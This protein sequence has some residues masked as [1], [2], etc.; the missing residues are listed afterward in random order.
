MVCACAV[1]AGPS[2]CN[3]GDGVGGDGLEGRLVQVRRANHVVGGGQ[4]SILETYI[5]LQCDAGLPQRQ[6]GEDIID[7]AEIDEAVCV[8]KFPGEL[9]RGQN[10]AKATVRLIE[11]HP[12]RQGVLLAR[13]LA[14]LAKGSVGRGQRRPAALTLVLR[15]APLEHLFRLGRGRRD[16]DDRIV[17]GRRAAGT[18][19]HSGHA[20]DGVC[21]LTDHADRHHQD[22][23]KG[24][25]L[26]G[27]QDNDRRRRPILGHVHDADPQ[28]ADLLELRKHARIEQTA[29]HLGRVACSAP[30]ALLSGAHGGQRFSNGVPLSMLRMV[31]TDAGML[32]G[33]RQP[34]PAA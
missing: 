20:L 26:A 12:Q 18:E 22:A 2:V 32:I 19:V 28:A 16:D 10:R 21:R 9:I 8:R 3:Q 24:V 34:S 4:R 14:D 11:I 5:R 15:R 29:E 31:S 30:R 13:L 17:V 27:E 1:P 33:D 6:G 7:I 23:A 25:A